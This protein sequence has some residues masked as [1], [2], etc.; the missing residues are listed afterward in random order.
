MTIILQSTRSKFFIAFKAIVAVVMVAVLAAIQFCTVICEKAKSFIDQKT[1]NGDTPKV[2]YITKRIC[3]AFVMW[4]GLVNLLC[5]FFVPL[6]FFGILFNLFFSGA[7]I[8]TAYLAEKEI[9]TSPMC[10]T[11]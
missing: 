3:S 10:Y 5:M 7:L 6:T 8:L 1:E 2:Q 11:S 9:E 4:L